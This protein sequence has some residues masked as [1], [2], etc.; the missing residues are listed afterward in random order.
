MQP[1]LAQE[2]EEATRKEFPEGI[3]AFGTDAL[4]FTF[5]ALASTGRDIRFDMKRVEGYRNFTNKIWN[6]ARYVCMQIEQSDIDLNSGETIVNDA[7][8]W[9]LSRLSRTIEKIHSAFDEYRFDW[10]AQAL[11]EF[12]WNEYCDWY[13]ELTKPT[14]FG[15]NTSEAEKRGALKVLIQVLEKILLL[16]HP[17]IP[18]I[19]EEIWQTIKP[20]TGKMGPSIMLESY[21]QFESEH[22]AP[23]IEADISWLQQIILAIRNIRGEMQISP[24]KSIPLLLRHPDSSTKE[25]FQ[26]YQGYVQF[27]A[28]IETISWLSPEDPTPTAATAVVEE[29][30]ILIPMAGLI[31]QQAEL[32]RLQK[33]VGKLEKELLSL[34]GRLNN[35]HFVDKAPA[36]V[37]QK[38]RLRAT[39]LSE[40]LATLQSK[41]DV[42]AQL[43]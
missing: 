17:L 33:E 28:K 20:Y 22:C 24:A 2:I 41:M 10:I 8:K 42:I 36:E 34:N 15:Q 38:E 40:T 3:P 31:D 18:Y 14:L 1:Q 43:S 19:T 35:P 4:R 27:L 13:L 23:K 12:T 5:C 30:E 9:I 16:S 37:V 25:R 7:A 21:P 6:A 39:E 29:L 32:S 26:H 11:Y